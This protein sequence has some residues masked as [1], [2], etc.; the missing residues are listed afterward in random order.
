MQNVSIVVVSHVPE[1][2]TGVTRL[3]QEVAQDVDIHL[4][5]GLEDGSIG[6]S[7]DRVQEQIEATQHDHVF[8]FYDLG[9]AK[10]NLEMAMDFSGKNIE[11]FD[12]AF[13]EGSYTAAALL[14][15]GAE[16]EE[17]RSQLSALKVDK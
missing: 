12:V 11:L 8:A 1:I 4:V 7:F 9:S 15:A 6:T 16:V 17:I 10:M 14:Q 3:L 13:I 2:T 5:G